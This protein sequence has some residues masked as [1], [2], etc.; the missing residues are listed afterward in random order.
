MCTGTSIVVEEAARALVLQDGRRVGPVGRTGLGG[1]NTAASPNSPAAR[2]GYVP[3]ASGSLIPTSRPVSVIYASTLW[4]VLQCR[5]QSTER[6]LSRIEFTRNTGLP[7]SPFSLVP[8][9]AS[10]THRSMIEER[11]GGT[12]HAA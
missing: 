1:A 7:I 5:L 4:R 11:N 8:R 9:V 12:E 10:R 6:E 2:S 3:R